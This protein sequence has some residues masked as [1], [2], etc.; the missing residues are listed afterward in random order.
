MITPVLYT[1]R[2]IL[3]P[4]REDEAQAVYDCWGSDA[5]VAKYMFWIPQK[6]AEETK[7]WIDFELGQIDKDDWYR[8][9]FECSETGELVGTGLIYYEDEIQS[10]E[11]AYNLGKKFW[12][13]GYTTEGMQCI[14]NFAANELKLNWITGRYAKDNPASGGVMKK[15]GFTYVKDI[16]YDCSNNTVHLEG[17]MCRL[18][19]NGYY[20]RQEESSDYREVENL[21]REAFWNVYRPGCDEHYMLHL[22]RDREDFVKELDCVLI[23]DDCIV[24]HIMYSNAVICC[25]DGRLVPV[26]IFGPIS[27]RPE[28]QRMGYGSAIIKYTLNQ[29]KCFGCGAVVITGNP[30]YYSRFG[31]VSGSEKDIYYSEVSRNEEAPF[32][33]VKELREGFLDGVIGSFTEPDGYRVSQSDMEEYDKSFP[34]KE[35][36][37]LPGQLG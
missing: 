1:D 27:V 9:A 22:Y 33:M 4:F 29:A 34:A 11:I 26:M 19:L 3:R 32:F 30:V 6:S 31:F 16:P 7:E 2:L 17:V 15:L 21:T 18:I 14:I 28:C 5:E 13:M 37:V 12:G 25:D 23:A 20:I 24:A 10:W 8:F 35:K 36:K